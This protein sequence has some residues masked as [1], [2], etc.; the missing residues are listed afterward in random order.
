M[1]NTRKD[2]QNTHR[3]P[4]Q[5]TTS[6]PRKIEA[7]DWRWQ[8]DAACRG[9]RTTV[10]FLPEGAR[11]PTA[12]HHEEEAK[13]VCRHC[14]VLEQCRHYALQTQEPY[15]VWGGLSPKERTAQL[16]AKRRRW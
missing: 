2:T 9:L 8:E 1:P 7:N 6:T 13:A 3:S 12:V 10:F 16:H 4:H 14:P 15:G 5:A 11:G